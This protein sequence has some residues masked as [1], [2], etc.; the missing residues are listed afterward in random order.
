MS[1]DPLNEEIPEV[2]DV[3]TNGDAETSEE[4]PTDTGDSDDDTPDP[5]ESFEGPAKDADEEKENGDTESTPTTTDK[6]LSAAGS[7]A[8]VAHS[9]ADTVGDRVSDI[10]GNVIATAPKL[11]PKQS[12]LFRRM[13]LTSLRNY[14]KRSGGDALG[15]EA[16]PGQ[17]IDIVPVKY[18]PPETTD[19][20]ERAGWHIKGRDRTYDPGP[21]GQNVSF[22]DGKVPSV[23]LHSDASAEVGWLAPRIGQAIELDNYSPVFV[24]PTLS[25]QTQPQQATNPSQNGAVA[26]GGNSIAVETPSVNGYD[27]IDPGEFSGDNIVDL[28]SGQGHDGMRISLKKAKEWLAEDADSEKMQMQE[29]RGYLAGLANN[30]SADAK[31]IFLYAVLFCLGVLA[32]VILGPKLVGGGGGGGS[33]NPLVA[34]PTGL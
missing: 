18:K 24:G 31:R 11:I 19:E 17:Q 30:N 23:L 13:A 25:P 3:E 28:A 27:M 34:L 9:A 4:T 1:D 12:R 29:E 5:I 16:R 8:D 6:A 32:I 14:H 20:E 21:D 15:I 2:P 22:I 26:D 33:I 10:A 7:A